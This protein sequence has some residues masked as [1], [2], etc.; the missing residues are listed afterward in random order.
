MQVGEANPREENNS[1]TAKQ[2]PNELVSEIAGNCSSTDLINL[3]PVNK[4]C[5][6][7]SERY[8]YWSISL[9]PRLPKDTATDRTKKCLQLL[10]S[11]ARSSSEHR[12]GRTIRGR[13]TQ[14]C[15]KP[16]SNSRTLNSWLYTWMNRYPN[17]YS[18]HWSRC[19]LIISV[20]IVLT[21]VIENVLSHSIRFVVPTIISD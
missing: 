18:R 6:I 13:C 4:A 17:F 21:S 15:V 2:F 7:Q 20:Y 8:L 12:I 1:Q 14:W 16:F 3:S 11:S 9:S 19:Y 5:H 10:S